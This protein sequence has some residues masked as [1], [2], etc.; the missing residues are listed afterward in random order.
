MRI[1]DRVSKLE[2]RIEKLEGDAEGN[3]FD[4]DVLMKKYELEYGM[5]DL[6]IQLMVKNRLR[7]SSVDL[8]R[9]VSGKGRDWK[10][11]KKVMKK[12]GM[13]CKMESKCGNWTWY[14][15]EEAAREH[16]F[17]VTKRF[18]PRGDG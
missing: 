17:E 10:S 11:V 5:K 13:Y 9:A 12:V 14:W 6:V 4:L 8:Q 1:R 16:G 2:A 3:N 18:D 15:T 7:M